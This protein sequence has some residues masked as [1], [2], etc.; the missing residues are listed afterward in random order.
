M[1]LENQ[2]IKNTL[3]AIEVKKKDTLI[4]SLI[5]LSK[6]KCNLTVY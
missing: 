5:A 6:N 3:W 1:L 2:V 4:F